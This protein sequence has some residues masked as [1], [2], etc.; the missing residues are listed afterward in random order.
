MD[1]N[2]DKLATSAE[3][4]IKYV[5]KKY[6]GFEAA[7]KRSIGR[8]TGSNYYRDIRSVLLLLH[9]QK[10]L[11]VEIFKSIERYY[12]EVYTDIA[13]IVVACFAGDLPFEM[14]VYRGLNINKDEYSKEDPEEM[15]IAFYLESLFDHRVIRFSNFVSTTVDLVRAR[16]S[17]SESGG[18]YAGEEAA[19][20]QKIIVPADTPCIYVGM[21]STNPADEKEILL[22]PGLT[23]TTK[24]VSIKEGDDDDSEAVAA[25]EL[26]VRPVD[27]SFYKSYGKL[28]IQT[29]I[30]LNQKMHEIDVRNDAI[31]DETKHESKSALSQLARELFLYGKMQDTPT[32]R[33]ISVG[34][35][36]KD[37]MKKTN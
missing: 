6:P 20:L 13:I 34:N 33:K 7:F 29:A 26:V 9:N 10:V 12:P 31:V 23:F 8:Y 4:S 22:P 19:L 32:K 28:N 35:E 11:N 5:E 14:T 36:N 24:I 37:R 30:S 25:V 15:E 17:F 21:Y 27:A 16:Y 2:L 1:Y 3:S 18:S